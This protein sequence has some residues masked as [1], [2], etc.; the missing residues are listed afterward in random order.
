[1]RLYEEIGKLLDGEAFALS[2]C[3][4]IPLG[5]GYFQGVQAVGDFSSERIELYFPSVKLCVT[6]IELAI[7]KYCDGDLILS[8]KITALT[9]VEVGV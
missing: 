3:L 2:R 9:I 6:G 7:K 8:G 5:G 1:M 4:L